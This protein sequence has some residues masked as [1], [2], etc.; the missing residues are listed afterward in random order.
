MQHANMNHTYKVLH[1]FAFITFVTSTIWNPTNLL[2]K[3]D[4]FHTIPTMCKA[5]LFQNIGDFQPFHVEQPTAFQATTDMV[6]R[7]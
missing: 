3:W 5:S 6:L 2:V 4:V 7:V 1:I